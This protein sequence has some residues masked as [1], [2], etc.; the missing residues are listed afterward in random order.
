MVQL[1]HLYMTTGKTTAL[2]I[3]TSV[4]KMMSLLFN[5]LM[6]FI[7]TLI[8]RSK[9]LLIS[10][11]QSLSIVVLQPKKINS[12]TVSTFSS[13]I[14][15]EVMGPDAMVLFFWLLSFKPL[16][17]LSSFTLVK[18]CFISSSLSTIRMILYSYLRL[19]IFLPEILISACDWS[20]P[21]FHMMYSAYKLSRYS[22]NI[23][24]WCTFSQFWTSPSFHVWF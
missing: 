3:Q 13:F 5:I 21:A 11:L 24:P 22:D 18:Q 10:W 12:D 2:T 8:P 6:R 7:I 9:C 1:L 19:L 17:S 15:H 23:Q 16:F 4:S 20:N 14:C